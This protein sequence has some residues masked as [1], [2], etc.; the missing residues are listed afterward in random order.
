MRLQ[1][2]SSRFR[3]VRPIC[4]VRSISWKARTLTRTQDK[5]PEAPADEP[6]EEDADEPEPVPDPVFERLNALVQGLLDDAREAVAAS[7]APVKVLSAHE[8][9]AWQGR[10]K[11]EVD[12]EEDERDEREVTAL[13]DADAPS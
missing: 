1:L 5:D 11:S 6:E 12:G 13:L 9:L 3:F 4:V 7:V 10:R 2:P 8:V